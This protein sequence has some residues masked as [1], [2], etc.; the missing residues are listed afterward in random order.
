MTSLST[1]SKQWTIIMFTNWS[2]TAAHD[3]TLCTLSAHSPKANCSAF[4]LLPSIL[5]RAYR[6][7]SLLSTFFVK[8]ACKHITHMQECV[9]TPLRPRNKAEEK[10]EDQY[11]NHVCFPEAGNWRVFI[12]LMNIKRNG[13]RGSRWNGG[14][15][16]KEGGRPMNYTTTNSVQRPNKSYWSV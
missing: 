10:K 15:Q 3:N 7:H 12:W 1:C 13:E 4:W 9:C 6:T 5:M 16:E 14:G 2:D 8:R 11:V